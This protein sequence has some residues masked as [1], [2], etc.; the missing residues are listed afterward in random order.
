[1]LKDRPDQELARKFADLA[2]DGIRRE[3]SGSAYG[4][5]PGRAG[6]MEQL[7][8]R[9]IGRELAD[10]EV[11]ES[12]NVIP[13][14]ARSAATCAASFCVGTAEHGVTEQGNP[15]V[16]LREPSTSVGVTDSEEMP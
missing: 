12:T 16:G 7:T 9:G 8:R 13:T 4:A 6:G 1:V 3:Y 2:I 5:S 15:L 10:R 14:D 11:C